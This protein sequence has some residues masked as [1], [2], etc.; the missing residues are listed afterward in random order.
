MTDCRVANG[1]FVEQYMD[2][3]LSLFD[4][5][6]CG[7]LALERAG[8]S[9]G[10]YY[11]SEVDK[12]AMTVAQKNFPDT[13]QL[14]DVSHWRDWDIDWRRVDLILGGSPCQ[15]F[16]SGGKMLAFDDPRS[17]L[18]FVY[19]DILNHVKLYNPNV[20]FLLENVRMPRVHLDII[21]DYLGTTPEFINSA[22]VSAQNRHR[23]YWANWDFGQPTDREVMLVDVLEKDVLA[24]DASYLVT[25][26]YFIRTDHAAY[27]KKHLELF[28]EHQPCRASERG[29]KLTPCGTRRDDKIGKISRGFECATDGKTACI[30]TVKKDNYICED[31]KIRRL[32]PLEYERLQTLPDGYTDFVSNT[33]RYKMIGNCWTV[34]VIAHILSGLKA[35]YA[36]HH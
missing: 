34:D 12:F 33:Q 20:K 19:V 28:S 30:T 24:R 13:V 32:T 25:D 17:R 4:G 22:L 14:G 9:V 6:S 5:I 3:V 1:V 15:G 27:F 29:R 21:T 35:E 7:R 10:S 8:F 11:A 23:Y 16:S 18:F 36:P 26:E 31:N 2:I